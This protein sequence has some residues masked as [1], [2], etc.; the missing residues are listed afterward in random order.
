[1]RPLS[2]YRL[3][4]LL[5]LHATEDGR[6]RMLTG[7]VLNPHVAAGI[8]MLVI[9]VAGSL[10]ILDLPSFAF[11]LESWT[12]FS[13]MVRLIIVLS[14]PLLE[15]FVAGCWFIGI[16]R[17]ACVQA[18]LVFI[19]AATTA[20]GFHVVLGKPPECECFGR[21]RAFEES[22]SNGLVVLIRNSVLLALLCVGALAVPGGGGGGGG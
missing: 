7:R 18:A 21:I 16:Y 14:I 10:K 2:G 5:Q 3:D 12:Y 17:G 13:P 15:L 11:S 6:G 9:F 1:M 20:Y 22:V 4:G 8:A 19:V